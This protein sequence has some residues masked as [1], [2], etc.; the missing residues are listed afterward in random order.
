MQKPLDPSTMGGF[1][2]GTFHGLV[3]FCVEVS[4]RSAFVAFETLTDLPYLHLL[5]FASEVGFDGLGWKIRELG[6]IHDVTGHVEL[7]M[8]EIVPHFFGETLDFD[9]AAWRFE[10]NS[11]DIADTTPPHAHLLVGHKD[12]FTGENYLVRRSTSSVLR[13][14]AQIKVDKK[15]E[16]TA[17]GQASLRRF[18]TTDSG[19]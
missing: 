1:P 10:I 15:S 3:E 4:P 6:L 16:R 13:H 18:I 19:K 14:A 11:R 12:L 2:L 8:R 7:R 9:N 17:R 5:V